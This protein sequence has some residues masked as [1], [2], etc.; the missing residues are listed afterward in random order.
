MVLFQY[1]ISIR[2]LVELL[3]DMELY[4]ILGMSPLTQMLLGAIEQFL[5]DDTTCT[6]KFKMAVAA[7][8]NL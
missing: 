3:W 4:F 2:V 8:W 7:I 1:F 5:S 6:P